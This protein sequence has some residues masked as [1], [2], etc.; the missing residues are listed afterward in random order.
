MFYAPNA[1]ENDFK[2]KENFDSSNRNT[3]SELAKLKQ[4]HKRA[5]FCLLFAVSRFCISSN[6]NFFQ[7]FNNACNL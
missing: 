1:W 3:K 7:V 5:M 6:Q 4:R 2:N